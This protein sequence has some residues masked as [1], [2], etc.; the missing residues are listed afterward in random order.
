MSRNRGKKKFNHI[1]QDAEYTV[2][3]EQQ[4][5]TS[6]GV[7]DDGLNLEDVAFMVA[8]GRYKNGEPF[9]VNVGAGDVMTVLGLL[10]YGIDE[11][12]AVFEAYRKQ[13]AEKSNE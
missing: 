13:V 7:I 1:V 9:V 6:E 8:V 11:V 4:V 10:E 12:K 5:P 3:E 2:L